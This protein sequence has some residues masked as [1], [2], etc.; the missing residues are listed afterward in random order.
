MQISSPT[1]P[2]FQSIHSSPALAALVQRCLDAPWVAIDTEFVRTNTYYPQIGLIQLALGEE[3]F[4]IDP[5]KL[6]DLTPLRE[7]LGADSTLK[8]MHACSED[9]EVF[10]CFLGCLPRPLFDTQIAASLLGSGLSVG[11][12]RLVEELFQVVLPKDEQRSDW[13]ARPL[14]AEQENYAI[15]D[16]VYLADIYAQQAQQLDA[17]GRKSW[18]EEECAS[19]LNKQAQEIPVELQYQRVKGAGTLTPSQLGL[20]QALTAWRETEAKRRNVPRGFLLKDLVM[21]EIVRRPPQQVADLAAMKTVHPKVVRKDGA[22]IIEI[23][24][25]AQARAVSLP[26]LDTLLPKSTKTLLKNM[27][28]IVAQEAEA[29]ALPPELLLNR[30]MMVACI[31][32][33][34]ADETCTLPEGVSDWKRALLETSIA[35]LLKQFGASRAC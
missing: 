6:D 12:K 9:L 3:Y 7:L 24:R 27:Q 31:S 28:A 34:L 20:L 10:Q 29:L 33:Y 8:I 25:Q 14:S 22:T 26:T 1:A 18:M 15:L 17:L 30:K 19:L 5:L 4:L 16:V 13:L 32:Q 35:A 2:Q 21:V 23:L 11:Y